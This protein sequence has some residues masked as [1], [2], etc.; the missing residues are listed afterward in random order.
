MA[1]D[2]NK[3]LTKEEFLTYR[4]SFSTNKYLV[5]ADIVNL[6]AS[7]GDPDYLV[8]QLDGMDAGEIA[9]LKRVP[10]YIGDNY[11]GWMDS[12][13]TKEDNQK[14]VDVL[15]KLCSA[16][17]LLTISTELWCDV[18][19]NEKWSDFDDNQDEGYEIGGSNDEF[20]DAGSLINEDAFLDQ[21]AHVCDA[22][23]DEDD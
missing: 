16:P 20:T 12:E 18:Q 17:E 8:T 23:E 10:R 11:E 2:N 7:Y 5:D 15:K 21:I 19:Q 3:K 14:L 6:I 13:Q 4:R 9:K 22:S 1:T